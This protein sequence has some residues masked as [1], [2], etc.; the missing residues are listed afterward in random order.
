MR[1]INPLM[2]VF[3]RKS[4]KISCVDDQC[5]TPTS[6]NLRFG[7]Y[8][9]KSGIVHFN[10]SS[11]ARFH[12]IHFAVLFVGFEKL[13][14]EF[15]NRGQ[16]TKN[17][18]RRIRCLWCQTETISRKRGGNALYQIQWFGHPHYFPTWIISMSHGP[19]LKLF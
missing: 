2:H 7:V 11:K 8:I 6:Q 14:S 9:H 19:R 15:E 16:T 18:H 4:K 3:I 10:L 1:V 17:K 12:R 5:P 13:G